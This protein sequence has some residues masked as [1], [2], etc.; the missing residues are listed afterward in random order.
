[1]PTEFN[2]VITCL[3]QTYTPGMSSKL[4]CR[5]GLSTAQHLTLKH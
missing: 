4:I 1:M 5:I 2:H 3:D